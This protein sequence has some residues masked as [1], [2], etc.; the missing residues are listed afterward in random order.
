MN[1]QKLSKLKR[2]DKVAIV[3]P[4]FAAPGVWPEVY[5]LGLKRLREVFGLE[6]VEYP[7]TK[8]V[9]AS[10][11]ERMEDL[12]DCFSDGDIRCVIAS[13]GGDDQV[14][15]VK[16]LDSKVFVKNPKMF[17]GFSDNTH[18]CNFL[19]LNG[20]P[21]FYGASLFTQFAMQN[22]ME[23]F[24][25]EYIKHAMFDEGKFELKASS[26]WN[27]LG[28]EWDDPNKLDQKRIY[29]K[30][31]G[32]IWTGQGK[33]EG[34]SWGGCV[35]SIDE[36]LRHNIQIPTL[37]QFENIVLL[38]ETCEEI[39]SAEYVFRVFR[40]LG[41]RRILQRVK[42]VLVGRP[43][44]QEFFAPKTKD[45]R[46][47]YMKDQMATIEKVVRQYNPT[48]PIVQRMDFGH[49]NPQISMPYGKKYI[50]DAGSQ[51]IFAEF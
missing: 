1:F 40:A 5:G 31:E 2:G 46:E 27:D 20:I 37:E 17:F 44:T 3:S 10:K 22:K 15:Y 33:V 13:L 9:G 19:W 47:K 18:F 30:N 26:E 43:Q 39:N 41:E 12:V 45:D 25:V 14:T 4:S 42:A 35:E 8:K 7:A 36:L 32:F 34:I 50:V 6:P 49:T 11:E 24:T 38:A 21:S 16:N 29:E 48:C 23:D 51:K 28:L